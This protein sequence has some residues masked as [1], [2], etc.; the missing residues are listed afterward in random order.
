[1]RDIAT[2]AL[3][4]ELLVDSTSLCRHEFAKNTMESLLQYGLPEHRR[5]LAETIMQDLWVNATDRGAT[6]VL[7]AAFSHAEWEDRCALAEGLMK[8]GKYGFNLLRNNEWG[9]HA[10]K[11][12]RWFAGQHHDSMWNLDI[13]PN[14]LQALMWINPNALQA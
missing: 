3:V 10:L 12:L 7:R 5:A 11:A 6:Y 8:K 1:M 9:I 4:E 2:L 14:A 13:N